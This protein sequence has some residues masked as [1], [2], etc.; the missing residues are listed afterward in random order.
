MQA[1]RLSRFRSF[2]VCHVDAPCARVRGW[3][4]D[5]GVDPTDLTETR[6]A[7]VCAGGC[8]FAIAQPGRDVSR[9]AAYTRQSDLPPSYG[10]PGFDPTLLICPGSSLANS[11][12]ARCALGGG[13][14]SLC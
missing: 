7:R 4:P 2:L 12:T 9:T 10:A 6:R 1:A 13:K 8:C 11:T 3:L 14:N 5:L